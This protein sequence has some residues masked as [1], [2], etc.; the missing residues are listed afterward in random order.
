VSNLVWIDLETTGL[1]EHRHFAQVLEIGCL[2][3]DSELNELDSYSA[4]IHASEEVL[5]NM[6][7]FAA[8]MHAKNGLTEACRTATVSQAEAEA[9]V[10]A[11]ISRYVGPKESALWGNSIGLDRKFMD[12]HMP[13]INNYLHYRSMDVSS[14]KVKAQL[15]Y[16]HLPHFKKT[17]THRT[18]DDIRESLAECAYYR[19]HIMQPPTIEM[20]EASGLSVV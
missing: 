20:D 1:K 2:I 5:A 18:L 17:E 13:S 12:V 16:T 8:G 19:K 15:W 9:A 14:D 10:L 6:E 3:T 11:L 7:P 4:V